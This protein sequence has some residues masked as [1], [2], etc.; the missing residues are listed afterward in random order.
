[1]QTHLRFL[2]HSLLYLMFHLVDG[3]DWPC[4][5]EEIVRVVI[6][7]IEGIVKINTCGVV[8]RNALGQRC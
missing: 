1:M 2:W 5:I 7:V 3:V 8:D 6:V 4:G